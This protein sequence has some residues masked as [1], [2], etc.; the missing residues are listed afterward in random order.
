MRVNSARCPGSRAFVDV[1][2]VGDLSEVVCWFLTLHA[3]PKGLN[4]DP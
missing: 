4:W 3:T 2:L 1:G